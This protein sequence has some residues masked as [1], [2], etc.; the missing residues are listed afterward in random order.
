M[1]HV[2]PQSLM[3]AFIRADPDLA[4]AFV[5]PGNLLQAWPVNL[6]AGAALPAFS[7]Q[8]IT[9]VP[10]SSG[11]W[12]ARLQLDIY[13]KTYKDARGA[14]QLV[15]SKFHNVNRT[16]EHPFQ[17]YGGGIIDDWDEVRELFH[18]IVEVVLFYEP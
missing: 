2:Q 7:Y 1:S 4:T 11:T 17:S 9:D 10:M 3:L 15:Q 16:P 14:A 8:T 18:E 13:A 6:A 12:R 5:R